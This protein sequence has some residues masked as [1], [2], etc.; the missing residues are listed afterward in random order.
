MHRQGKV[1]GMARAL[2]QN[3]RWGDRSQVK[4]LKRVEGL[5]MAIQ[6]K[7]LISGKSKTT[8][9]ASAKLPQASEN[10]GVTRLAQVRLTATKVVIA[11]VTPSRVRMD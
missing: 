2:R 9:K 4:N 10:P 6:K 11:R 8:K 3:E 7:S 5:G 1:F